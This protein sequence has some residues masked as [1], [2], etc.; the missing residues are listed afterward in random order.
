VELRLRKGFP[1]FFGTRLGVT[2]DLF[3][4][5]NYQNLDPGMQYDF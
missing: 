1:D 2:A 5:F 4:V 3:N